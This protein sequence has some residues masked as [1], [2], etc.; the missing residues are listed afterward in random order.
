MRTFISTEDEVGTVVWET[1]D[2]GARTAVTKLEHKLATAL[3]ELSK[4]HI[5]LPGRRP[6]DVSVELHL[7]EDL[8][9][10]YM[11]RQARPICDCHTWYTWAQMHRY[12]RAVEAI[13]YKYEPERMRIQQ[14]KGVA[15]DK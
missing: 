1:W 9:K 15:D 13:A 7:W 12:L 8:K 10:R 4:W 5:A 14:E 3:D 11:E 6:A 2:A